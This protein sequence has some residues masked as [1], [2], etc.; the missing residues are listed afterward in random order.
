MSHILRFTTPVYGYN[1][2]PS[3]TVT[4]LEP[5]HIQSVDS[6]HALI[7]KLFDKEAHLDLSMYRIP[8]VHLDYSMYR[9]PGV[10]FGN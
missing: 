9:I 10:C 7:S 3:L 2:C 4:L 5:L 6:H 8:G 1:T